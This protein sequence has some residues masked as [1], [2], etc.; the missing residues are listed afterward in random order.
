MFDSFL[1]RVRRTFASVRERSRRV[2]LA[3]LLGGAMQRVSSVLPP[4]CIWTFRVAGVGNRGNVCAALDRGL[5]FRVA[6]VGNRGGCV[7]Q[8][9]GGRVLRVAGVGL[10]MHVGALEGAG[11]WIRVAGVENRAS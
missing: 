6:G 11:G 10:R 4:A 3:W 2:R 8:E 9:D 1:A 7:Y 5:A